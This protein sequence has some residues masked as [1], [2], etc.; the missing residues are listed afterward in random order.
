MSTVFASLN[1]FQQKLA[2]KMAFASDKS[3]YNLHGII[4]RVSN[5]AYVTDGHRLLSWESGGADGSFD[6]RSGFEVKLDAQAPAFNEVTPKNYSKEI[7]VR[8]YPKTD[9]LFALLRQDKNLLWVM[10]AASVQDAISDAFQAETI[11][12]VNMSYLAEAMQFQCGATLSHKAT[13]KSIARLEGLVQH[14]A[15]YDPLLL[16]NNRGQFA[17]VMPCRL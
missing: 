16:K 1:A 6:A 10:Q 14:A 12:C 17:V 7:T 5:R 8:A 9:G 2:V 15:A 13:N 11:F 4:W 3:R